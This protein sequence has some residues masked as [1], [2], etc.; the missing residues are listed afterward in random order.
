M[1]RN[2]ATWL[3]GLSAAVLLIF[4]CPSVTGPIDS[5]N[6]GL[7]TGGQQD[8]AQARAQ[9]LDGR[10]PDPASITIEG[11]LSEHDVPLNPS[12]DAP[13]IYAS[14]GY[15]WRKPIG[16]PAPMVDLFARFG[17]TIDVS[18]YTRR[19]QNLAVVVDRSGSMDGYA[20]DTDNRTKLE[21]VQ[22]ALHTL[23][24]QLT[25]DDR[26]AIISFNQSV[27][28]DLELTFGDQKQRMH[29]SIDAL[30]ADGNTNL[31]AALRTGFEKLAAAVD[32]DH[33]SRL[34]AF[35]DALPTEGPS[36]SGEFLPMQ[37]Q[38]ADAGIGFTL[39]GVG[40]SYGAELAAD[41]SQVRG[42]NAFYLSDEDRIT[43][44]FTEEFDYFVTPAAYDVTLQ[45]NVPEG[46]GIREVYGVPDYIPGSQGAVVHIPTLFFSPREGGGAIVVR[47]SFAETPTFESD[48]TFAQA[49]MTYTLADG[50]T[51]ELG[52]ALVLPAG[53]SQTGE[54]PYYSETAVERAALL[55]DAA[56]VL[57][58]ACAA[59]DRRQYAQ[60]IAL[61]DE[62]LQS[63]DQRTLGMSDRTAPTSRGLGD[64]RDLL[65]TLRSNLEHPGY[66]YY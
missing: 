63:F 13:E 37:R 14:V 4:G 23:V 33:D 62:F 35:T 15:A 59:G 42:G 25:P 22:Q 5:G 11:F 1:K 19:S 8:V 41:I 21:A 27:R 9:I 65:E 38:F 60:G 3:A 34:I 18:Q 53:L 7:T 66:Y 49:S 30:K 10:I 50:S 51:R 58:E 16:E 54:P 29:Q 48:V 40:S 56:V 26:L 52:G 44:I 36:T 12:P 2:R 32:A 57:K 46:I 20:S 39:M 31:F 55:L 28:V 45:L 47:L 64:E 43:Q 24:D 6:T 61:I 17:T